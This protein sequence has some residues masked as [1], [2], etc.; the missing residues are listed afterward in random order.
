MTKLPL[1]VAIITINEEEN[2]GRT[3]ESMADIASEI[4]II[5]SGSTDN[6][7]KIVEK[8]GA[9]IF[10]ETWK[11]HI[12]QKNSA[13]DKCSQKWLLSL[14]ADEV[15]SDE[16]KTQIISAI[17]NPICDGYILNRKTFYLGK[18][19][20]HA[21]QPDKKIRLVKKSANP[22]W[23]GLNP[24]DE[25]HIDG[26]SKLLKG[27]LVHYSYKDIKHHF[28]KTIDYA[29]QSA[30]SYFDK[31]KKF[32]LYNLLLNPIIAFIRLYIINLGFL[33]GFRGILAGFSSYVYTFL[34]YVFLWELWNKN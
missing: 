9:K 27:Y 30:R 31:G 16:L 22:V 1:S 6:T 26:E 13:L 17:T 25:L 10:S 3:L 33:D 18:L 8:Y 14:D 23:K 5:D 7:L 24:H 11:G 29:R 19:L 20:K 2:I 4:I 34:K 28:N 21:W 15:V 12:G 32:H